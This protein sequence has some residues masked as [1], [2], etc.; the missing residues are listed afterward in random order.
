MDC[1]FALTFKKKNAFKPKGIIVVQGGHVCSFRHVPETCITE[2][3]NFLNFIE[4]KNTTAILKAVSASI[5]QLQLCGVKVSLYN[6]ATLS[7]CN[8]SLLTKHS[9]F[10]LAPTIALDKQFM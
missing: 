3:L 6:Y 7:D 10:L 8:Q 1:I 5:G 9:Y 4:L 2:N